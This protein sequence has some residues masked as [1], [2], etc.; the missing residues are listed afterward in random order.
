M[1]RRALISSV[2]AF[3]SLVPASSSS[4]S[5]PARGSNGPSDRKNNHTVLL[6]KQKRERIN[7]RADEDRK[8]DSRVDLLSH[9]VQVQ[10]PDPFFQMTVPTQRK[11]DQWL[12]DL[13][14]VDD[15]SVGFER[16]SSNVELNAN[17][18]AIIAAPNADVYD[19]SNIRIGD[20]SRI[21][22]ICSRP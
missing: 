13:P 12:A 10:F 16:S 6:Q 1:D 2:T 9:R 7:C 11:V 3:V 19:Q 20:I 4:L 14:I 8:A 15:D 5:A 22:R 21:C 17:Q 18:I